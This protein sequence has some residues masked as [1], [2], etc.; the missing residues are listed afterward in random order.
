M[1]EELK[2]QI[3]QLEAEYDELAKQCLKAKLK[4]DEA[5]EKLRL[6]ELEKIDQFIPEYTKRLTRL[7]KTIEDFILQYTRSGHIEYAFKKVDHYTND[8]HD[9]THD[10]LNWMI[11]EYDLLE[12]SSHME[13]VFEYA[14]ESVRDFITKWMKTNIDYAYEKEVESMFL[15]IQK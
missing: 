10:P 7:K 4:R 12:M 2:K 8:W 13:I 11:Q 15:P 1:A 5:R 3:E 6:E 14:T 9:P